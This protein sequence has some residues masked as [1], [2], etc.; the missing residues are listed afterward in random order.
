MLRER[1]AETAVLYRDAPAWRADIEGISTIEAKGV[2]TVATNRFRVLAEKL[3]R[4]RISADEN[5]QRYAL[6]CDGTNVWL[7]RE[8]TREYLAG[9]QPADWTTRP[10]DEAGYYA[11]SVLHSV[12]LFFHSSRKIRKARCSKMC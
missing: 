9:K 3:C 6:L 4:L 7:Y 11:L 8:E 12:P 10:D 1:L 2:T 5:G